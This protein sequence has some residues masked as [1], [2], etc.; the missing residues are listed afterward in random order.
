MLLESESNTVANINPLSQAYFDSYAREIQS[1]FQRIKE[2][3]KQPDASGDYHE[4]ILRGILRNFLTDRF[5]VKTGFVYKDQDHV[6]N[7]VDILIIDESTPATYLFKD[8]QF[9]IVTPESVVAAIEVKTTLTQAT[10]ADATHKLYSVKELLKSPHN[11]TTL[12]F[13]YAGA[14]ADS[15][16]LD[17]WF[18]NVTLVNNAYSPDVFMFFGASKLVLKWDSRFKDSDKFRYFDLGTDQT[19]DLGWQL[20]VFVAAIM[21]MCE[22]RQSHQGAMIQFIDPSESVANR[23]MQAEGANISDESYVFGVGRMTS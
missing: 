19:T 21:S 13:G 12:V 23:L 1:K 8:E 14:S 18:K 20:S 11:A 6:S 7:Q 15:D 4:E 9:V 10:F 22:V 16:V 17:R 5:S 2:L 3:T